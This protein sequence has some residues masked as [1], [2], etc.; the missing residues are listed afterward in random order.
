LNELFREFRVG[1]AITRANPA[2][3]PESLF[4][5]EAGFDWLGE[6]TAFRFTAFRNSLSDLITNVTLSTSPTQIIR[7]RGNAASALSRG[8]EAEVHG[9][10]GNWR[11]EVSYLFAD[12]RVSTGERVTQVP[13]HQGAGLVSYSRGGTLASLSVRSYARQ[14]EDDR[15]LFVLPGFATVQLAVR[16]RLASSLSAIVAFENLFDREF[17]TGLTPAPAIGAPRLWRAGLRWDGAI[18]R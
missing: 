10:A 13:R 2:L 8:L 15:N 12:A 6:A 4:G 9:R 5:A 1:N 11:G 14:F 16:Q 7:Q 18:R 17:L 3:K